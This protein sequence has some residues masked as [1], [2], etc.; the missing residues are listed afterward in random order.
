MTDRKRI[1][2]VAIIVLIFAVIFTSVILSLGNTTASALTAADVSGLAAKNKVGN[3][4]D[5]Y[6]TSTQK[7][8]TTVGNDLVNKLFGSDDPVDYIKTNGAADFNTYKAN[9]PAGMDP[10]Y[11]VTSTQINS[12]A[13]VDDKGL[14]VKLGG[15]EWMV[16]SLTL[17]DVGPAVD[18]KDNVIVTLYLANESAQKAIYNF[19][20]SNDWG[21]PIYSSSSQRKTLLHLDSAA[22]DNF[23]EFDMFRG[24]TFAQNYIVQPKYIKYQEVETQFGRPDFYTANVNLPNDAYGNITTTWGVGPYDRNSVY[25]GIQYV[26]WENDYLWLP[27]VTEVGGSNVL[28]TSC[29]WGLTNDQRAHSGNAF[30]HLRSGFSSNYTAMMAQGSDGLIIFENTRGGTFSINNGLRPAIHLNIDEI[31]GRINPADVTVTYNGQKQTLKS[32]RDSVPNQIPWYRIALEDPTKIK[33]TYSGEVKNANSTGYEVT[34][35]IQ[36]AYKDTLKWLDWQT[37]SSLTRKIKIKIEQAELTAELKT[38]ENGTPTATVTGGFCDTGTAGEELK[39]KILR[40]RYTGTTGETAYDSY[41]EQQQV[42]NY[43]ATVEINKTVAGN[44]NK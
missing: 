21:A 2:F 17:A 35:T 26:E 14:V 43:T 31:A 25:A 36:N 8:N 7:L 23:S 20:D 33:I 41:D 44:L 27:S 29:I 11:V 37:N 19:S 10:Y 4:V 16:A 28:M 30:N 24:G 6:D 3:L 32:I 5:L 9:Y 34:M 38:P 39:N 40:I 22:T 13:G 1:N 15:L 18:Q 42:G 12:K